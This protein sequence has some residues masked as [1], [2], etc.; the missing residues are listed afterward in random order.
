MDTLSLFFESLS[1]RFGKENDLSDVTW[2]MCQASDYFKEKWVK[3]FFDLD[4]NDVIYIERE[5]P[6]TTNSGCRVDFKLTVKDDPHPY[7]IEVKL[8]DK[9][10]HFGDYEDAY[11]VP[12]GKERLGYITNY[13]HKENGYDVKQW[14][15]F[16]D[17]LKEDEI[18][19]IIPEEDL[20]LVRGYCSYLN[21]ICAFNMRTE[22]IDINKLSSLYPLTIAL[23]QIA[24]FSC[25]EFDVKNYETYLRDDLRWLYLEVDYKQDWGKQYPF[26]GILHSS[27]TD[28]L[29]CAGFDK[30][31][32]WSQEIVHFIRE[33][34]HL[35]WEG[36]YCKMPFY[37]EGEYYFYMTRKALNEFQ[38]AKDLEA[39]KTVLRS[40]L[41]EVLMFPIK[42]KAKAAGK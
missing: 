32:T 8:W 2:A 42:L 35:K 25:E 40:F 37:S 6:D 27:P 15:G 39:Q 1:V 21:K 4:V 22:K 38:N 34:D 41:L 12:R 10:H 36:E 18:K 20:N 29:I 23:R 13:E 17:K 11:M 5:I 30:R 9:N 19:N 16:Y 3:F 7:L 14:K 26:M 33:N 24:D 31:K 28:R